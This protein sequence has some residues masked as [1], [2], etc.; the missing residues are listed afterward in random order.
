V[1]TTTTATLT[2][3]S[4][5]AAS[6]LASSPVSRS[7]DIEGPLRLSA[8]AV[9]MSNIATGS[10]ATVDISIERWSTEEERQKLITTFLEKGPDKLLDALQDLKR[11]GYIRLPTSLGY[12][13]HFARQVPLDEGG[14]KILLATDRRIGFAEARTQPRSIDYPFTLIEIRLRPDGT[15]EGKMSIATK[16]SLN[17][18]QNVVELENYSSEPVR[19]QNV[20]VEKP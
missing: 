18:K 7:Q 16:I 9:N 6:T 1:T 3:V 4:L 2:F 13:L 17:K 12:D 5:I 19:L 14:R 8:W 11:V 10:N 15:G 20:K